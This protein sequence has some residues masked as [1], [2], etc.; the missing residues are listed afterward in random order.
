MTKSALTDYVN[1]TINHSSRNGQRIAKITPHYMCAKWSGRQCAD[2]FAGTSRQASSNYCIGVDG[3]IALSVDEDCRAWTSS[4]AW[5]DR[6]AITIECGNLADSSL[7]DATWESLVA[8]C[9]DLCTRYG[10]RLDY[11]GDKSGTLTEHRMFAET[12]CPGTWLHAHMRQLADEVNA[13]LDGT[14]TEDEVKDED[15]TRI[16]EAVWNFSQNGTLMR[17]RVQGTD[18]A[19]N[20][21]RQQVY[22]TADPTGRG[23]EL[24]DHD[25]IK[26]IAAK[27]ATMKDQLDQLAADVDAILSKLDVAKL[28]TE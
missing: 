28:T 12:D 1:T 15:I 20:A 13:R 2:Y 22:S 8:L 11:T 27:Q 21:V 23:A 7:T 18:E 6:Q 14:E 17:D 19:A 16:A 5:N 4:S 3:D 25:H 10:F 24:N 26:W 9:T